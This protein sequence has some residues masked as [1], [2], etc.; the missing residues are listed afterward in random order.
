MNDIDLI[1]GRT[2]SF[3]DLNRKGPKRKPFVCGQ[4]GA[5]HFLLVLSVLSLCEIG[6]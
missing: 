2:Q 5:Q 4:N 6:N 3:T 1:L